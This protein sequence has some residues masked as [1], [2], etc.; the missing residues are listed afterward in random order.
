MQPMKRLNQWLTQPKGHPYYLF[1]SQDLRALYPDQSDMAFKALMS[2]AVRTGLLTRACRG[3]YLYEP[4]IPNDGLLLFHIAARLRADA[5]NYISLETVL[6]DV[7]VI[8]QIP[9][10]RISLR[11]SGR[12]NIVTCGHFGSI[13]FVHT[14]R[15]PR[16]LVDQLVYDGRCGLWRA[17]VA[18]ALDDMKRTHRDCDLI[19][20]DVAHEFI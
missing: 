14:S 10:N 20:W 13:E 18:L 4:S 17:Q 6:S 19:N 15:K 5:F 16:D 11:S 3:I 12:S 2:R 1:A 9:M 8:A 7:G